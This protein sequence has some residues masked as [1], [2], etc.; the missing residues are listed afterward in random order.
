MS[1]L[2]EAMSK[3]LGVRAV[4]SFNQFRAGK[5]YEVDI[6]DQSVMALLGVG[7]LEPIEEERH[8]QVDP[9]DRV[10][11]VPGVRGVPVV[12]SSGS[13]ETEVTDVDDP[14]E[15]AEHASRGK[16]KRVRAGS[17]SGGEDAHGGE[18]SRSNGDA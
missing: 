18:A 2:E 16:G 10:H 9:G 1:M 11:G 6:E 17:A 4:V 5:A 3:P 13:V 15:P 12:G 8:G 14:A 7:Y